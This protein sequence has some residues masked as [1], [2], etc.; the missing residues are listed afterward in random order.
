M[1]KQQKT[2]R[3]LG[4]G[5]TN[6]IPVDSEEHG[7][8]DD[9]V[10]VDGN[11][12]V[13]NPFQPRTQFDQQ[14]IDGLAQSIQT[15]GLLQPLVVRKKVDGYEVVSGER[16]LRA[17]R[18]LGWDRIPCIVKAKVTDHQM[19]ELALVENV[20]REDLNDIELAQAYQKLMTE[21]NLSHED[22]SKRVG[23]SRSLITN[24]M[25]LLKLPALI[26]ALVR[27]GKLSAGHARGILA[28]E[29]ADQQIAV[30]QRAVTE[31]LSV[32]DIE[33]EVHKSVPK[34]HAQKET[35]K[36]SAHG[37]DAD[38][39]VTQVLEQ[40]Q[41][42]FG[43]AVRITRLGGERG[44]IEIHFHSADDLNRILDILADKR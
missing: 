14:E 3:A 43:T 41:Y 18:Q 4:R 24:T 6:L 30:A 40:M 9:V 37:S 32:R 23:K 22:L 8:N 26:Q 39:N 11:A 44:K 2:R 12:I 35:A 19:L 7:S 21:F 29:N 10:L 17:M 28:I 34:K 36:A 5:L 15:Q 33:A 42:R 38:P 16:R 1:N 31:G 25:R 20:Q 27:D 13:P